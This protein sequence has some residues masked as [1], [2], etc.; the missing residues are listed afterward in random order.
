MP[1]LAR[2]FITDFRI[3]EPS[4][5]NS[6]ID[7]AEW[8]VQAHHVA[9]QHQGVHDFTEESLRNLVARYGCSSESIARRGHE[10]ADLS[11][12]QWEKM[13]VYP[14]KSFPHGVASDVRHQL[15]D[16][17]VLNRCPE[18]LPDS[19]NLDPE[20]FHVTCTGYV[21]PSPL[22]HYLCRLGKQH[23]STVTHLYHMGCYAALPATRL[24][25]A[26][27]RQQESEQ[28]SPAGVTIVHTELCSLH[29][30]PL[31][32]T[33]EQ[34]VVQSLFSDGLVSYRVCGE[35]VLQESALRPLAWHEEQVAGSTRSITW[36]PGRWGML[37]GLAR[38]V[39]DQILQRVHA[40][41]RQ[42]LLKAGQSIS[43][44][45]AST[46]WAI[47]PGGP[48][49]LDRL[50]GLLGLSDFQIAASREVLRSRG[51]MSSATIPH[52]WD[53]ILEAK[54]LYPSGTRMV[55]IAFG[56]GITISMNLCEVV[57]P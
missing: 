38:D 11:H 9:A 53:H 2:G 21:A 28:A 43:D 13:R 33:P 8:R 23:S 29:F 26:L 18:L 40:A 37:M 22:Q 27:R 52:I 3:A 49:I 47:H 6:Q 56:P 42:L 17:L 20:I 10:L 16:E 35:G 32:V 51:N 48:R 19:I 39:P 1:S 44:L 46:V 31:A 54:S 30:D 4:F 57:R 36:T 24:A 7:L 5:F 45:N 34:L 14:L 25:N 41:V 55:S 50:Q 15:F 12:D